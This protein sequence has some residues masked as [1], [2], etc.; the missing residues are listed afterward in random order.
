MDKKSD[1]NTLADLLEQMKEAETKKIEEAGIKHPSLIGSMYEGLTAKMMNT[2]LFSGL[3]L[4]VQTNCV[5]E[6]LDNE[7]DVIL[8]AGEGELLP[9]TENKYRFKP[10]QVIAVIQVKKNLF[11]KEL[12]DAYKN[13][14]VIE[15][16]YDKIP[17][18]DYM[19]HLATDSIRHTLGKD[20]TAYEKGL[21]TTQ[22]E[23][24]YHVLNT[25][26]RLP[27]RILMGYNGFKSEYNIRESFVDYLQDVISTSPMQMGYGPASFPSLIICDNLVIAKM[28]G[29][30]Y[31]APVEKTDNEIWWNFLTTA[32]EKTMNSFLEVLWTKLTYMFPQ[33]PTDIFGEDLEIEQQH[34]F[35]QAQIVK[36][37]GIPCGWNYKYLPFSKKQLKECQ[38]NP[39]SW[40]PIQIDT[41]ME[42]FLRV[43][44]EKGC[45]NIDKDDQLKDFVLKSGY[46]SFEDFKQNLLN[47]HFVT[48]ENG[49]VHLITRELQ[50]VCIGG[51]WYAADNVSSQLTNWVLKN[52]NKKYDTL[53]KKVQKD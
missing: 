53:V 45:I 7:F 34:P 23:Y 19:C 21:M 39:T 12:K 44:G 47:T 30:P 22:E 10:E 38:L 36:K 9:C 29:I 50:S 6:G 46:K 15:T 24:I 37:N 40:E 27:L 35:L 11:S 20:F 2:S 33:I 4:N 32:T 3:G 28:N 16:I 31:I 8:A 13:L 26:S 17:V 48:Y 14:Q 41:A 52:S 25:E 5:I 43:L 51:I 49:E 18:Q 42:V 1:I